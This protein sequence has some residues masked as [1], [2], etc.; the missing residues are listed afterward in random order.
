MQYNA[1]GAERVVYYQSRQL[2]AAERNYPV[3]DK[4]LLAMKYAQAKFRVYL[5]GDKPFLFYTDHPSLRTAVDSPHL[6]QWM[7]RCLSSFAE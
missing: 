5:F 1:D 7:A 4:E 3:N 2:Q 6:S